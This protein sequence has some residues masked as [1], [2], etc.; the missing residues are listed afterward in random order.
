VFANPFGLLALLAVPA[1]VG[2]HL[3]RRRHVP[4]TVAALF[5]W[6]EVA[7]SPAA[8]RVRQPLVRSPSF[9]CEILAALFAAL[10]FAGP[11]W[12]TGELPHR[13]VVIDGSA[14]MSAV[15]AQGASAWSRA[16]ERLRDELSDLPARARVSLIATGPRPTTLA[17]PAAWRD[18]ALAALDDFE[19]GFASHA[20]APALDL[21]RGLAGGGDVW[22]ATDAF[23]PFGEGV[24]V[25]AF[26]AALGNTALVAARRTRDGDD[27][28]LVH[29]TIARFGASAAGTTFV[30]R[31]EAS[32]TVLAARTLELAPGARSDLVFELPEGAGT[33]ALE[34]SD[35]VAAI[36]ALA[37]DNRALLVPDATPPLAV[38]VNGSNE[39]V[40]ATQLASANDGRPDR[41]LA[42]APALELAESV[43]AAELVLDLD[44]T[45]PAVAS[46][47]RW[48][49]RARRP[50]APV[51]WIGPFLV[52]RRHPL[53]VGVE[54]S[55]VAW[56]GDE[57]LD[58]PG[59]PIV[60]AGSAVLVADR[61]VDTGREITLN[62]DLAVG[63]FTRSPDWPILLTNLVEWRRAALPG[64]RRVNLVVGEELWVGAPEP[65]TWLLEGP[66]GS[67][68]RRG[69]RD[70]VFEGLDRPGL[71]EL[72]RDERTVAKIGVSFLDPS[73]SD[74]SGLSSGESPASAAASRSLSAGRS[75]L[76]WLLGLAALAALAFDAWVLSRSRTS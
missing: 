13:V 41:L 62:T 38:F 42:I 12:F 30:L 72:A 4:H 54:L 64:P 56:V 21:A 24:R 65:G 17:G 52:E 1:V 9:W 10:A 39:L 66:S 34:L 40:R 49:L 51:A 36:D 76:E 25:F 55:G 22:F 57:T 31:D 74:L 44:G 59:Q 27:A 48:T 19:P 61:A 33:L 8:G 43:D 37:I 45:S 53:L 7:D 15:D 70:I 5:L 6:S 16:Q 46:T 69:G 71:H 75:R 26:G 2:L 67:F 20:F 63:T 47:R 14:S 32:G 28:E 18:E 29:A 60:S 11:R 73:E 58:L 3:Y 68:E 23:Q 50:T 35:P